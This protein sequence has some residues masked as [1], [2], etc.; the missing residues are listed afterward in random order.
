MK[1][2]ASNLSSKTSEPDLK[3]AFAAHG[4]V[5]ECRITKDKAPGATTAS[6]II[7][8]PNAA[9]AQKA[10]AA[11]NESQLSGNKIRVKESNVENK[12][13]QKANAGR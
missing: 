4:S 7:K 13:E 9:E 3:A 8:M 10:I 6:G 12:P 2:Y 1:L 5:E 11:L